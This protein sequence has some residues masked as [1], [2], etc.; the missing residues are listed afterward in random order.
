MGKSHKKGNEMVEKQELKR[1]GGHWLHA[2][3]TWM[4][5]NCLN[6]SKVTWGSDEVLRT[7]YGHVTVAQIE[8]LAAEVAAVAINE[9]EQKKIMLEKTQKIFDEIR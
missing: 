2:V 5:W 1:Q 4:Q 7:R 3:R 6:G 9:H 8:D